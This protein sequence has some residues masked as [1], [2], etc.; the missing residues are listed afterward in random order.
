M[1]LFSH[2]DRDV[3]LA[4]VEIQHGEGLRTYILER[5]EV[6]M[7]LPDANLDGIAGAIV[8]DEAGYA[9]PSF[10]VDIFAG[11]A[12][13]HGIELRR[14]CPV[15]QLESVGDHYRLHTEQG[16][17]EAARVV[18][19]ANAWSNSILSGVGVSLPVAPSRHQI[20]F[21]HFP[22]GAAQPAPVV[23]DMDW[24]FYLRPESQGRALIGS[25]RDKDADDAAD[26]DTFRRT[27]DLEYLEDCAE[28]LSYRFPTWSDVGVAGGYCGVYD[29]TPDWQPI[30]GAVGGHS[31][32]YVA[33]GF[34]GHGFKLSPVVG[35]GMAELLAC[36][37]T[38][39]FDVPLFSPDRFAEGRLIRPPHA[40]R[41]GFSYR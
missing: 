7:R 11:I 30:I 32:L 17:V 12:S 19:A 21:V 13:R 16:V 2:A 3:A 20:G 39:V 18:V 25:S 6:A 4:N 34:S 8:E 5:D 35:R 15:T 37:S 41:S 40:Y 10:L 28:Y 31:G 24:Q 14:N 23:V 36:G 1:A 26:P 29:V 22:A 33:C 27:V 9:E 38:E